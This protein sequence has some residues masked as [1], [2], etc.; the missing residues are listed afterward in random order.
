MD[1]GP[2][3]EAWALKH[4]MIVESIV[5]EHDFDLAEINEKVRLQIGEISN[6]KN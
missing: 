1:Q 2:R 5:K 4:Q 6:A 3:T